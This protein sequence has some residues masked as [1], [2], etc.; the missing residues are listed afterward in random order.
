MCGVATVCFAGCAAVDEGYEK[1]FLVDN[2][3]ACEVPQLTEMSGL[4]MFGGRIIVWFL[5][6]LPSFLFVVVGG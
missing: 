2:V 4:L 6:R 3:E 1:R 5:C